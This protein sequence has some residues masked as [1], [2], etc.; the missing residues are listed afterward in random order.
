MTLPSSSSSSSTTQVYENA[1]LSP[2][3]KFIYA[4]RSSESKRQY[5]KRLEVFLDYL[6][7]KDLSV[8]EKSDSFCGVN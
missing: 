5:P 6:Q 1:N 4:L 7:I 2:H 3:Q 8:E